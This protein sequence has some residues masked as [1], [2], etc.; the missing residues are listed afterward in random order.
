MGIGG[1]GTLG[2]VSLHAG[3]EDVRFAGQLLQAGFV[4]LVGLVV[5][6]REGNVTLVVRRVKR[7]LVTA[8]E[9]PKRFG[10]QVVFAHVVHQVDELRVGLTEDV[11]QLDGG[12]VGLLQRLAAKEV[13]CL[14][15]VLLQQRPLLVRGHGCQLLQVAYHQQLHT[16]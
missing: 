9:Y 15:A 1:V 3:A 10:I 13:G 14:V 4:D 6:G 2:E 7:R 16:A 12:V 11:G 5:V 8:V